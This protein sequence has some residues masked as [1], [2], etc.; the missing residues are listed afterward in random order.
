MRRSALW[1]SVILVSI[2]SLVSCGGD[3]AKEKPLSEKQVQLISNVL[4]RNHAAGGIT[5]M[6]STPRET[7]GGTVT[8]Q[9]E[10]DFENLLGHAV[11]LGGANPNPVNEVF[12][13]RNVVLERRPMLDVVLTEKGF[14]T[15]RYVARP[16]DVESRRL[17]VLI[18]TLMGMGMEQPE[19]A[20]LIR[21]KEG[22]AHV[23]DDE[24]RGTKVEVLRYGDRLTMWID[25]L[26]GDLMRF[27][28]TNSR[29]TFPII[30]D[31]LRIGKVR[32]ADPLQ[33]E[34]IDAAQLG[35]DFTSWAPQSP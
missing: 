8:M 33:A 24:L 15:A 14:P 29:R 2:T 9:G 27:E 1:G 22:S 7:G 18:S 30:I 16:V 12:W 10:V 3:G 31:I 23:R 28:G 32:I 34:V 5:F 11:V 20:V 25:P 35:D 21:Q 4:Y 26:T 13:G 6:L 17:D 19:N